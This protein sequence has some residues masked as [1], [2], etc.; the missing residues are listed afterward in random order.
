MG[1]VWLTLDRE[2]D[3]RIAT[4]LLHPHLAAAKGAVAFMK[5]ECRAARRLTHPHIVR[6]YD[7]HQQDD[8]SF[9]SMEWVN[10]P[11]F[12]VWTPP[13][14][15]D[16]HQPLR[17]LLAVADALENIHSQGLVHRDVKAR[18]ILMTPN[19]Q[20]KL[21]DF[22]IAGL[23]HFQPG[24]LNIQSGGSRASM[25]PQQ[26]KGLPPHP[27][28]DIYAFGVLLQAGLAGLD[29]T[30]APDE[31]NAA[32]DTQAPDPEPVS[33]A[34]SIHA[35][36]LLQLAAHMQAADPDERPTS[37]AK[38]KS[39][40]RAALETADPETAPPVIDE[41]VVLGADNL[42]GEKI[43]SQPYSPVE[44]KALE[45]T[46]QRPVFWALALT[47][48]AVGLI[49][50]GIWGIG[51]LARQ[52]LTGALPEKPAETAVSAPA[53]SV[54]PAKEVDLPPSSKPSEGYQAA[55]DIEA[56]EKN[57]AQWMLVRE[58]LET[59]NAAEWAPEKVEAI[60]TAAQQADAAM[61]AQAYDDAAGYYA[62]AT[63]DGEAL[64]A[65]RDAVFTATM[66]QGRDSLQ[67]DLP[68][69][70]RAHFGQALKIKP[71]DTA[72]RQGMAAADQRAKV[73]DLMATG[74]SHEREERYD[75][76]L[77]DYEAATR[78]DSAY[79]PARQAVER[80]KDQV[81]EAHYNHLVS[82]G[83][84]AFYQNRFNEAR[85][86]I[87]AALEYRP[88]GHEAREALRQIETA[89]RERQI[90]RLRQQGRTAEDG[91][92]WDRALKLYEDALAIDPALQF[93][94]AG[95][96]RC[97]E[98]I[99]INKRLRYYL[100]HPEN[101]SSERYLQ[102]ARDLLFVAE[103]LAPRGPQLAD[104]IQALDARIQAAQ[105]RIP[106]TVLSD[107]ETEVAVLRVARLGR[108]LNQTL[109][110]RPG[111]YTIV[112][113][114]DGYKDVR[115]TIRLNADQQALQVTIACKEKI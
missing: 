40:L 82:E 75:L 112:G 74:Q 50:V 76:A 13:P 96:A 38:V 102:E 26:Q 72:A 51:I 73:M 17:I 110:L 14:S 69:E 22:G 47:M 34:P 24:M 5:N 108:I 61:T 46:R 104:Q 70:A 90:A 33:S 65:S 52:P 41:P 10:G 28:D 78:M 60:E 107:G 20:P 8:L 67:A 103:G 7:F 15:A 39:V 32:D 6:V 45:A 63:V 23:W 36:A 49:A 57:L 115:Q 95:T 89:A 12:D 35:P 100:D 11:T 59:A 21:T 9:I 19:G 91:E 105:T 31:L 18:N 64:L 29:T 3:I 71:D 106:L 58:K 66:Q 44:A 43:A 56:A 42:A 87:Q 37:M 86:H 94:A 93:A 77:A 88:G 83:L 99:R 98:R 53:P 27:T 48:G 1:A 113:A 80:L 54:T 111:I 114:R 92:H 62:A 30:A 81:A 79:A 84:N 101:L 68:A 25:S 2:L 4:K 55:A 109:E 85:R 97:R 16:P